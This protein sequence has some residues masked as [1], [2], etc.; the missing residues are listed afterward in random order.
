MKGEV[1]AKNVEAT[2]K[3]QKETRKPFQWGRETKWESKEVERKEAGETTC[4]RVSK[5]G[6][7]SCA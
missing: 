4:Y 6:G 7:F 2:K 5:I 3:G 1:R